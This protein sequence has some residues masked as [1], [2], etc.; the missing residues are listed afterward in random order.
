MPSFTTAAV[1]R[2]LD[3]A[4]L[5]PD[6]TARDLA[7]HAAMCVDRGVGC[8]CVRPSD[9]AAAVGLLA[10]S[11]VTVASVV[12]FPHGSHR[13]E[14]KA[15]EA[16]LALADGARELDMVMNIGRFLSGD[17][18]RVRDDIAA[19][20]AEAKP[21]GGLVKVILETCFLA[22]GQIAAACLLA[23]QAG[24]D[25]VKTS[26]GYG[27]DGATPEAVRIMLDTVGGRLGVKASGGIRSWNDAVMY[28]EMGCTRLGVGDAARI[29][30]GA[31]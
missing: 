16:R 4:V 17:H 5:R 28:L 3:H 26:T 1:A 15:L 30:D 29:L 6:S 23:E 24:A 13:S 12:G 2:A 31:T 21:R 8:L 10:G 20:V 7:A 9:V 25:F 18:K 14:T 27:G 19:V 11:P 22:P